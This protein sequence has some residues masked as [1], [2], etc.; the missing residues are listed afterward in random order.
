MVYT[1]TKLTDTEL[2]GVGT[3]QG[4]MQA[5]GEDGSVGEVEYYTYTVTIKFAKP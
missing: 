2:E 5:K 3:F 4:S 1:I